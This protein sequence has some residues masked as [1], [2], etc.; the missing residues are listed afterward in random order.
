MSNWKVQVAM[1]QNGTTVSR[2]SL[3]WKIIGPILR[4]S[5][6]IQ[7]ENE[8]NAWCHQGKKI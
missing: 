4:C 3:K 7:G 2:V 6:D 1:N 5:I 8:N